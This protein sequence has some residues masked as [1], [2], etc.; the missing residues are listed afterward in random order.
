MVEGGEHVSESVPDAFLISAVSLKGLEDII[1][2]NRKCFSHPSTTIAYIYISATT[3][4]PHIT[5]MMGH[6]V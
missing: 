3:M 5:S 1:L 2:S 4:R 6:E